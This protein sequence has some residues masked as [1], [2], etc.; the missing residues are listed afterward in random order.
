MELIT[1]IYGILFVAGEVGV[2]RQE[3]AETL[4]VKLQAI[5]EEIQQLHLNLQNDTLSPIELVNYNQK[6]RL[7]TKK[8][9]E[10]DVEAFA[11][12]PFSQNLTR[13]SIETL[14]IIAYR[15]PITRMAIDE[16]RGVQSSGL[17]QKL[18]GRDLVKETGRIEAPGRPVL[19]G[20]TDYFMDYFGLETLDDLPPVEPLALNTQLASDE[21]F[22][23]KEWDIE[24]YADDLETGD[25]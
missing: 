8:E 11:Q 22:N 7:V 17:I 23:I 24:L 18:I 20:V 6:Y 25:D 12:A 19:Y 14:A 3:L 4:N 1:R 2:S 9:L 10:N 16:I 15:Q 5:D 21:L 13:A